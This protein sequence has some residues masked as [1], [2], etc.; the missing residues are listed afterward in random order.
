MTQRQDARDAKDRVKE[1]NL[2]VSVG[3]SQDGEGLWTVAVR[4]QRELTTAEKSSIHSAVGETSVEI[5]VKG[6]ASPFLRQGNFVY[7]R[8][9]S[10]RGYL[11][12]EMGALHDAAETRWDRGKDQLR[13]LDYDGFL[14]GL[15][16][17]RDWINDQFDHLI[18]ITEE[19]MR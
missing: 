18:E 11:L 8:G 19:A 17:G 13:R 5:K 6:S 16:E 9:K 2:D 3:L 15:H 14:S 7:K 1:L 4:T 12:E 10:A